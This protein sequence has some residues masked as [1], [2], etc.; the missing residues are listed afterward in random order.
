MKCVR[1]L[2]NNLRYS[3]GGNYKKEAGSIYNVKN[4]GLMA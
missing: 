3:E 2:L 4:T 1:A